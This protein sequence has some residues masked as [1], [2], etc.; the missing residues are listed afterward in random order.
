M[1]NDDIQNGYMR[2]AVKVAISHPAE[3][4]DITFQQQQQA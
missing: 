4:I 2:V 1:T 3:F